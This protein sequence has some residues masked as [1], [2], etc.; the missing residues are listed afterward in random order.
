MFNYGLGYG[1]G[2][3]GFYGMDPLYLALIVLTVVLGVATQSYIKRTYNKW[4]RV[5]TTGESGASVARRMLDAHN[6]TEVGISSV[7][8]NLTDHFDPRTNKLYLSEDN[9][10]GG[11]VASV[12]VA[13]HEAGHAAQ[14]A[15]AYLPMKL[16]SALVPVVN[17]SQNVWF[18]VLLAGIWMN[19]AGLTQL[20]IALFAFSVA[21]HVVTLPVEIDASRRAVAYIEASGMGDVQVRGAKQVLTAAAL[22]YVAAALTSI[23]QLLYLLARTQRSRD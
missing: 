8:G 3:F 17:V 1:Y 16:R 13:C 2:G 14:A 9:L 11:S 5:V 20:A 10:H 23:L 6:C 4:S 22:T 12:A 19:L 15:A 7:A 18:Y 21:F